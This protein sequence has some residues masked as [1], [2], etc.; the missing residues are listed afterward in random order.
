[1]SYSRFRFRSYSVGL[2]PFP[3][4]TGTLAKT[5]SI[6]HVTFERIFGR[7][8]SKLFVPLGSVTVPVKNIII[9]H[10][11]IMTV[12]KL[13]KIALLTNISANQGMFEICV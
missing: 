8:F 12:Q 10:Y 9:M 13:F 4:L 6:C 1:M 3:F 5:C 7:F 2:I 11:L